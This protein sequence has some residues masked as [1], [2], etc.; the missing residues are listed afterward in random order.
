MLT[1]TR[2]TTILPVSD[3]DRA[4]HFY[5]DQLGLTPIGGAG[6]GTRLFELGRGDVLGLMPAEEGAQ[7]GH[8]V[9]SFEVDDLEAEM[10]D[11]QRRGVR[12]EDYDLPDLKTVNHVA[13]LGSEKAAWFHDSEG[14]VLCL[15]EVTG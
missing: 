15:H 1:A 7:S 13:V 14:N 9:L 6:D 2:T 3:P 5:T 10:G 4:S 8:T 12:F 11:L